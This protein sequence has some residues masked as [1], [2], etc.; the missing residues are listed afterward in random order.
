MRIAYVCA[1]LGVPVFGR[2]GCSIHVQEVVR[3]LREQG[4]CVELF[5]RRTEGDP[6]SGLEAIRIHAL[7]AVPRADQAIREQTALAANGEVRAV[8]EQ[9]GPF[10]LVYERYSLWSYAGMEYAR[11]TRTPGLLEVNAP[12]IEEQAEH[13]T[14]V[15]RVSAEHVAKRVFGAATRLLAVSAEVAAYL[16]R[17]AAARGRIQVVPNGVDPERFPANIA[18]SCPGPLGCF[19]VGFVGTLKP[20][21]GLPTLVE[22]FAQLH[23][24]ALN[25]RLLIVGDGPERPRLEADL[26]TRGLSEAAQLTGSV[27]PDQVPGLLASVGAAVAPYPDLAGFYFSP[28]KVYEYMA[29]GLPVVAGRVGQLAQLIRHEANGLLYPPGDAAA[30]AAALECLRSDPCLRQ[31]LGEAARELV[32]R[33]HTWAAVARRILDFAD[34]KTPV[35]PREGVPGVGIPAMRS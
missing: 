10:D 30:L 32:R 35:S 6:P 21:H 27:A 24:G 22:A 18:P 9:E 11:E 20:W 3:A 1:D 25:S 17:Y 31:R 13:R 4:A 2:K 34:A 33:Q 8:L 12:L 19:T 15:D 26:A 29:A 28:L 5:A 14:L 23:E 7:P 16:E